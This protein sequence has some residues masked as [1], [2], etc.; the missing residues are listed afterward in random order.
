MRQFLAGLLFLTGSTAF[1]AGPEVEDHPLRPET[2]ASLQGEMVT[3]QSPG[4]REF[5]GYAVGIENNRPTVL[6]IHE[7]WG[8]NRPIKEMTDKVASLGYGAL[9]ID[10][11]DGKVTTNPDTAGAYSA[12]AGND[13][14]A[15]LD[16]LNAALSWLDSSGNG[17][18]ATLGWCFGG[19]WSLQASLANPGLVDGTV[20]YYGMVESDPARLRQLQAPVIGVFANKDQWITS[21][22]VDTFEAGLEEAK[23]PHAIHRYDADHAFANPSG[24]YYADAPARDAWDKTA[25]FLA[26]NLGKGGS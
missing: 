16:K 18:V 13:P 7:W 9:A 26:K 3:L 17:R 24:P 2:G 12:A 14:E 23:V 20:I 1:A 25:A 5:Q 4:G 6:V 22:S 8:L 21:E 11:Y 10:L 19:G 15:A